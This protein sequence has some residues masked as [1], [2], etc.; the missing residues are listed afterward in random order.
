VG[1][2]EAVDLL[3]VALIAEGH[4]LIEDAPGVGKT[5]LA[6]AFAASLNLD[7]NRLQCTPDLTPT[8]VKELL[9]MPN[10]KPISDL[11]NYYEK[12]KASLKLLS[13]LAR[14]EQAGKRAG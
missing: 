12:I 3:L 13:Q 4:L 5:M 6:K 9:R 11:R 14:G 7:F 10:I 2:D 1:K 8:D